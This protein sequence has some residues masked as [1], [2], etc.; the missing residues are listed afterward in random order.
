[1]T[2]LAGVWNACN[3]YKENHGGELDSRIGDFQAHIVPLFISFC[4][5]AFLLPRV[6]H[7]PLHVSMAIIMT[8]MVAYL[9]TPEQKSGKIGLNKVYALYGTGAKPTSVVFPL[10]WLAILAS[11]KQFRKKIII[12]SEACYYMNQGI[13]Q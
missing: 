3:D 13:K 9:A 1:M 11:M 8:I 4:A 6:Q 2:R 10:L 5:A 12:I 7:T